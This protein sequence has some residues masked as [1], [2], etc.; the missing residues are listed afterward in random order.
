MII[1]VLA[2]TVFPASGQ[3]KFW[4]KV[5]NAAKTAKEAV[6]DAYS[7][8]TIRWDQ[9]PT[10][11]IQV[12]NVENEDGTVTQRAFL[13]D[14]NGNKRSPET[15]K[16]VQKAINASVVRILAKTGAGA[17]LGGIFD[18]KKGAAAGAA[19]GAVA[20]ADDIAFATKAQN[21]LRKDEK[22]LEEY[23]KNFTATGEP[24]DAEIDLSGYTLDE[25]TMSNADYL[26]LLE[27]FNQGVDQSAIDDFFEESN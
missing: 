7:G 16:A 5:K 22:K 15:V 21:Q 27:K 8:K 17:A 10:Y 19:A 24:I 2:C 3:K 25:K 12:T 1:A 11:E 6:V 4:Q 13:V 23:E 14:N 20:S 18:G 26:A 9:I